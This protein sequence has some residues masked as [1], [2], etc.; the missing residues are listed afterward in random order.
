MLRFNLEAHSQFLV[1][2]YCWPIW[3]LKS[4][5]FMDA[6]WLCGLC[7]WSVPISCPLSL[8]QAPGWRCLT[9][10]AHRVVQKATSFLLD[11]ER[12]RQG[13]GRV[14][15]I[16]PQTLGMGENRQ[17]GCIILQKR[18]AKPE[19]K[20]QVTQT[21]KSAF[22]PRAPPVPDCPQSAS[23]DWQMDS[24]G[25][26]CSANRQALYNG[27]RKLAEAECMTR[28]TRGKRLPDLCW[29]SHCTLSKCAGVCGGC[30]PG[31][32]T[33]SAVLFVGAFEGP[34]L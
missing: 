1:D 6:F 13:Q 23:P 10:D 31:W 33:T 15:I 9:S 11:L 14:W 26:M 34:G 27:S 28:K 5:M 2:S 29:S 7:A 3:T 19:D 12:I 20:Q 24:S 16:A 32:V 30:D 25:R 18:N 17:G 4:P 21:V 8:S 22:L